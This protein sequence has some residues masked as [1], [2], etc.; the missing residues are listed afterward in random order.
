VSA[1]PAWTGQAAWTLVDQGVF[2]GS[3]FLATVLLSRWLE[4]EAYGAWAVAFAVFV[5]CAHW[6]TA[7]V[8]DPLGALSGTRFASRLPDYIA[9]QLPVH[10][11]FTLPAGLAVAVLAAPWWGDDLGRACAT[12]GLT[13]P[14]LLAPWVLRRAHYVRRDP[15]AAALGSVVYGTT[16]LGGLLLARQAGVLGPSS[17]YATMA[18]ASAIGSLVLAIC[19]GAG[20]VPR[21]PLAG[22][23]RE[24]W[25]FGRWLAASSLL[26]ALATQAPV[27]LSGYLLGL[28]EAGELRAMSTLTQPMLLSISALSALAVPRMAVAF[29]RGDDDAVSHLSTRLSLGLLALAVAFEVVLALGAARIEQVVY[30]GRFADVAFLLPWLGVAPVILALTAGAQAAF[31]ATERPWGMLVAAA[32]WAPAALVLGVMLTRARGLAGAVQASVLG[33]LVLGAAIAVLHRLGR[34]GRA[35]A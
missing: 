5:A 9:S 10:G 8:L 1:R 12:V 13:L 7:V 33:Y 26:V 19:A 2:S 3:H 34:G 4:A 22:L 28:A 6:H 32:V 24:H 17:A 21:L 18:A 29:A 30:G 31:Q 14:L 23:V 16:F 11:A 25:S 35:T 15:R 20:A 27:L